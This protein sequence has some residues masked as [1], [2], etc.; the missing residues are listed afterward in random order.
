MTSFLFCQLEYA[1]K[2]GGINPDLYTDEATDELI[3]YPDHN[4]GQRERISGIRKKKPAIKK[5]DR[6]M[7]VDVC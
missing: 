6:Y 7:C 1:S 3:E 5:L 4:I 2:I